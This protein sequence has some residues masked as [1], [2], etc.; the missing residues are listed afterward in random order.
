[1]K[2]LVFVGTRPEIIK[3]APIVKVLD[4]SEHECFLVQSGQHIDF[5]MTNVFFND[6]NLYDV[7]KVQKD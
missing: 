2:I 5:E 3:M 1:M 4:A 6:L 7:V